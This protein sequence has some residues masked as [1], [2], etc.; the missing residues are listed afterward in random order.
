MVAVAVAVVIALLVGL[1]T[2]DTLQRFRRRDVQD[3][4][5]ILGFLRNASFWS[6]ERYYQPEA[7][8]LLRRARW[9]TVVF[10]VGMV[11]ILALEMVQSGI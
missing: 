7:L 8:P 9:A 11:A 4:P 10:I 1:V 5:A 6:N 2:M 3:P